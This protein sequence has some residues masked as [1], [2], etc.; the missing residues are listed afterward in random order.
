[1]DLE[2]PVVERLHPVVVELEVPAHAARWRGGL[3][4][5]RLGR[6]HAPVAVV[7]PDVRVAARL[8]AQ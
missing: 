3:D 8:V 4:E 5:Q 7:V 1:M 2:V 6:R